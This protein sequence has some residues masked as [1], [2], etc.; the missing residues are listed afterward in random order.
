M[1]REQVQVPFDTN[2]ASAK[3]REEGAVKTL[4][5]PVLPVS[6]KRPTLQMYKGMLYRHC[7]CRR[8]TCRSPEL[9]YSWHWVYRDKVTNKIVKDPILPLNGAEKGWEWR[10]R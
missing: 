6:L 2:S 10:S 1:T 3:E 4:G 8:K 9:D 7:N 5:R